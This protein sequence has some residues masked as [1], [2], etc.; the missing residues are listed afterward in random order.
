METIETFDRLAH[1]YDQWFDHH[2]ALYRAE[3]E[4]LRRLLPERGLGV[5]VGA[6]TGRFALPLGVA[7]GKDGGDVAACA[8]AGRL[9]CA[10]CENGVHTRADH[11][12]RSRECAPGGTPLPDGGY[13]GTRALTLHAWRASSWP[14]TPPSPAAR[15]WW[16][17]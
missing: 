7:L 9:L 16:M 10:F 17:M 12:R 8:L 3:V 1:E 2:P 13:S 11:A 6:G 4:T 14:P 5:E 15:R